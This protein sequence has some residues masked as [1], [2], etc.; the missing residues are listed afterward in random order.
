MAE[1]VR[2]DMCHWWVKG[3]HGGV[4]GATGGQSSIVRVC[5]SSADRELRG[6][7]LCAQEDGDDAMMMKELR[8]VSFDSA[9]W[10]L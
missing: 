8:L 10:N 9:S 5:R 1:K 3:A 2:K 7:E 6:L 4:K